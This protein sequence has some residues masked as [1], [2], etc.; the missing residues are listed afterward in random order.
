MAIGITWLRNRLRLYS[1]LFPPRACSLH[2]GPFSHHL[3]S[4]IPSSP[5]PHPK[6]EP[7]EV[8]WYKQQDPRATLA[9]MDRTGIVQSL[10][11]QEPRACCLSACLF[12]LIPLLLIC[13][14]HNPREFTCAGHTCIILLHPHN[15]NCY[16]HF[17]G[18]KTETWKKPSSLA[19]TLDL[20][21]VEIPYILTLVSLRL[22]YLISR[23]EFAE[24]LLHLVLCEG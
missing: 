6:D 4:H 7:S 2:L 9:L 13:E 15:S 12:V 21:K 14:V 23:A 10:H 24:F 16:S 1:P 20:V 11:L 17:R 8:A 22:E 19:K 5:L 3:H 18:W